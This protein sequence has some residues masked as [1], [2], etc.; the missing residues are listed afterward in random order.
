MLRP[1]LLAGLLATCLL[2]ACQLSPAEPKRYVDEKYRF[3]FVPP[4]G[5]ALATRSTPAC[6]T[7]VEASR[8]ECRLYVCVSERPEDFLP[9]SSDFANCEL[10]KVYVAE[11]LKGFNVR[12]R[13]SLIGGRRVYD[14]IYL[15]K[16]AD[17]KGAV[18]L[19]LV[20]Q[21]FVARG[22][23]LYTITSYVFGDSEQALKDASMPCDDEIIRSV[24]TFFLHGPP[25]TGR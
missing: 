23:L 13:P 14:A 9:T 12:C 17:E 20:R 8:G 18:R 24:A 4:K 1:A 5:W 2:A 11:T 19:Q 16:V 15:R 21:T 10:V 22:R 6:L 25:A 7:S 3:S